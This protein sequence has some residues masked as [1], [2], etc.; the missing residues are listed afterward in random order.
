MWFISPRGWD[1]TVEE[2]DEMGGSYGRQQHHPPETEVGV[3]GQRAGMV[4]PEDDPSKL[5]LEENLRALEKA[6]G[7]AVGAG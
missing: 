5:L 3:A 1:G 2:W 6:F 7:G 4:E